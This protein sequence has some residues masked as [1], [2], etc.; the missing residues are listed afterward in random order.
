MWYCYVLLSLDKKK[1]YVGKTNNIV[2]RIRQHN[3]EISGGARS[4]RGKQY[5][6]A[7]YVSGFQTESQALCFEWNMKHPAGYRKSKRKSG[8]KGALEA[9]LIV[10]NRERWT[11]KCPLAS[12]IPLTIHWS[13]EY[14]QFLNEN[15]NVFPN[16]ISHNVLLSI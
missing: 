15:R 11:K 9:I 14:Q 6:Y 4:T 2:K 13:D 1:T 10:T 7:F 3:G 16:F 8:I 5:C 12:T